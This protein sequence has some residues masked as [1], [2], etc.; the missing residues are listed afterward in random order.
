MKTVREFSPAGPC[1]TLCEMATQGRVTIFW[2]FERGTLAAF[3]SRL[4]GPAAPRRGCR[5][6][7][8]AV[9]VHGYQELC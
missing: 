5:G 2:I 4:E 6:L 1:L 9:R 7:S 3:R 8:L